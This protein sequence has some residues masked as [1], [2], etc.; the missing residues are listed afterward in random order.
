MLKHK[1]LLYYARRLGYGDNFDVIYST[2]GLVYNMDDWRI[3]RKAEFHGNFLRLRWK[4]EDF[5]HMAGLGPSYSISTHGF[6]ATDKLYVPV[7]ACRRLCL[8]T[9][10]NLWYD[11]D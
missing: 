2:S 3:C 10:C 6:D 1:I 7:K 9:G 8:T 4:L 11:F 5:N